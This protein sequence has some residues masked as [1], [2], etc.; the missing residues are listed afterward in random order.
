MRYSRSEAA[1]NISVGSQP[2]PSRIAGLRRRSGGTPSSI[3]STLETASTPPPYSMPLPL[4][5]VIEPTWLI[6]PALWPS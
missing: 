4:R 6:C 2:K 5:S 3:S 1:M